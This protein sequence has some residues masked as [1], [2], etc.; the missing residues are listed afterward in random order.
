MKSPST[1]R[2]ASTN[3][4]PRVAKETIQEFDLEEQDIDHI[5]GTALY[6]VDHI[7]GNIV[8]LNYSPEK[9]V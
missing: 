3:N 1:S 9:E 2:T 5:N 6:K 7:V 4:R 8:K